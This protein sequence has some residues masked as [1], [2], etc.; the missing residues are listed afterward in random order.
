MKR[1]H[2]SWQNLVQ[3]DF[4]RN[5]VVLVAGT[6]TA[7]LL[8]VG[9]SQNEK[10]EED[11]IYPVQEGIE[12]LSSLS[13]SPDICKAEPFAANLCVVTA[14][15][16]P[17]DREVGAE[18]A[19]VF[20]LDDH[21]VLLQ[22]NA[23]EK[24]YPASMTKVMTALVAIRQGRLQEES[25]LKQKVTVGE[26]VV[27]TESGASLCHINPG[28][29]LTMEQLLYGLMLPSG[30]DAGA[31]IAVYLSGSIEDFSRLM[32]QEASALGATDTH[33]MNPHGL[34]DEQ[35]YTTAYDLYLIF[36]E[37]LKEPLFRK[38]IATDSYTAEYTDAQ[39]EIKSQTWNNSNQYLTG[40][41]PMPSGLSALGGKTGTTRAAGSCLIMGS[42]DQQGHEYV[43][44]VMKAENRQT[45]YQDMTNI[46]QKIVN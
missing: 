45:L 42:K 5:I 11:F 36:Q 35:H 32:N 39:G 41:Q 23:F 6:L 44:V 8:L 38:I 9:C 2:R 34:H 27:I 46:I 14:D 31:A 7:G 12:A 1:S 3:T 4:A 17:P 21:L 43:S 40:Q 28:D 29:T 25:N 30:N 33:F 37:A 15:V 16:P 24:L 26:E 20:S 13:S 10:R 19:A 18:A 22:R